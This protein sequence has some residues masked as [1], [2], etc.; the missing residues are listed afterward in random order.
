MRLTRLRTSSQARRS[1]RLDQRCWTRT[2]KARHQPQPRRRRMSWSSYF[3]LASASGLAPDR[4]CLKGTALDDF[5][6]ADIKLAPE[7]GIAPPTHGFS[8]HC[9]T[10]LSYSGMVLLVGNAPTSSGYQPGALLLSYRRKGF[11]ASWK[12]WDLATTEA[13]ASG[14]VFGSR[15][16][17]ACFTDKIIHQLSGPKSI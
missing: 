3:I 16:Q 10:L 8:V 12:Q 9:S 14:A 17:F 13:T 11:R 1:C 2:T 5:V 15:T 6:F 7:D 4:T